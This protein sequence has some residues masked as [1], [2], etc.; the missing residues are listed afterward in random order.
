MTLGQYN[1]GCQFGNHGEAFLW[2]GSGNDDIDLAIMEL[3][4]LSELD[5]S[6]ALE[7]SE[8]ISSCLSSAKDKYETTNE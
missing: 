2:H 3:I 1:L 4:R 7:I 8:E 5:L 6:S